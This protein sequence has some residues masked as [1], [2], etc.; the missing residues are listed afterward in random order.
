MIYSSSDGSIEVRKIR[1]KIW[2]FR[3]ELESIVQERLD[4]CGGSSSEVDFSD[5]E[6]LYRSHITATPSPVLKM[7]GQDAGDLPKQKSQADLKG[8]GD[9][10]EEEGKV[11]EVHRVRPQLDESKL[12][13][14]VVALMDINLKTIS[15]FS[16]KDYLCGQTIIIEFLIPNHFFVTAE[17]LMCRNYNM[18][19]RIISQSSLSFRLHA[20]WTYNLPGERT[21][22]KR[23][24]N[25]IKPD[26]PLVEAPETEVAK[27]KV[28][29]S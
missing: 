11:L 18:R 15:C 1:L 12:N 23:F 17:V 3:D 8:E 7:D 6:E 22:M 9:E 27:T 5:L 4:K 20:K 13:D 29:G 25:S 28:S 26:V 16:Q 10:R 24:L 14:G 21:M 19:S 2:K